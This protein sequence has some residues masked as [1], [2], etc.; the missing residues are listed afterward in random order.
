M[1]CGISYESY[2]DG[3]FPFGFVF[4]KEAAKIIKDLNLLEGKLEGGRKYPFKRHATPIKLEQPSKFIIDRVPW[5][6]RVAFVGVQN[7]KETAWNKVKHQKVIMALD[8][9]GW[10]EGL[11]IIKL[12]HW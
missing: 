10:T 8:Q 4:S 6:H 2:H 3:N 7:G 12:V 11:Q 9:L 5:A 1:V